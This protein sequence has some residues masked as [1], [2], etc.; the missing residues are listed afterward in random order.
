MCFELCLM[1]VVGLGNYFISIFLAKIYV[2]I[3]PFMK[4]DSFDFLILTYFYILVFLHMFQ[5]FPHFHLSVF[6]RGIFRILLKFF[7]VPLKI[8]WFILMYC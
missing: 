8:F 6:E 4:N 1:F 5:I 7:L 3:I 2:L